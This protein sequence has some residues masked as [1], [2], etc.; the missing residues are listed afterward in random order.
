MAPFSLGNYWSIG[1]NDKRDVLVGMYRCSRLRR[2]RIRS[3]HKQRGNKRM[4][5]FHA[6][7]FDES[8]LLKLQI[9]RGYIREWLPVF[10]TGGKSR[11]VHV[12]DFFA[13]P[14][15]DAKGNPGSPLIILEELDAFVKERSSLVGDTT[16]VT[17]HFNDENPKHV[18]QVIFGSH[19]LLGLEKFLKVCWASDQV[20]GEANYNIDDDFVHDAQPLLWEDLKVA[21]KE[22]KFRKDLE[23]LLQGGP[24]TNH[25]VY[26]FTL[27]SGFLPKHANHVLRTLQRDGMIEVIDLTAGKPAR[28]NAFY[29][30]WDEFNTGKARFTIRHKGQV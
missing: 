18:A 19:T 2:S 11:E 21:K 5:E 3:E 10:L 29:V 13:G 23:M 20:T 14:G 28:R 12:Y 8:T 6:K 16:S 4:A 27:E 22:D 24:R 1:H 25:D 17:L 26:R 7:P 15:S 9:F 30:N